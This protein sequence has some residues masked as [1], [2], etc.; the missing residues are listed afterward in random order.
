VAAI[1]CA[2]ASKMLRGG[3]LSSLLRVCRGNPSKS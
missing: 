2:E 3:Q 1:F